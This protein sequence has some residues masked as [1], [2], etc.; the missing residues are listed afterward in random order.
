M[1]DTIMLKRFRPTISVLMAI[2][3]VYIVFPPRAYAYLDPGTGSYML[4]LLIAALLAAIVTVR[5]YWGRIKAFV[6]GLFTKKK[7]HEQDPH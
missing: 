3:A 2:G 1:E 6:S 5:M 4:Q 7:E